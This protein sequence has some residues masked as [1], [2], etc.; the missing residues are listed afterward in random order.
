M[1]YGQ[2][3]LEFRAKHNLTQ[4]KLGEILGIRQDVLCRY[5]TEKHSPTRKN[6]IMYENKMKEWEE[7]N[8]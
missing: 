8:V 1:N 2:K 5:E 6:R 7:K 4:R 3:L